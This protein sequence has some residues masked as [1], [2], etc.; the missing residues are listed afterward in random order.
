VRSESIGIRGVIK[1]S[2][3][4]TWL[5]ATFAVSVFLFMNIGAGEERRGEPVSRTRRPYGPGA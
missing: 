1:S 2:L 5:A 4:F 3:A